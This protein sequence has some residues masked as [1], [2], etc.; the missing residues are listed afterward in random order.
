MT[1]T[2]TKKKIAWLDDNDKPKPDE[3][4]INGKT[5]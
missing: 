3:V 5:N 4:I 1:G 2:N